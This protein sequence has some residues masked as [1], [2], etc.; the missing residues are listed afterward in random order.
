MGIFKKR[1]RWSTPVRYVW[2]CSAIQDSLRNCEASLVLSVLR[3]TPWSLQEFHWSTMW[4]L[5][6]SK[7]L[8][9]LI[10]RPFKQRDWRISCEFDPLERKRQT[11]FLKINVFEHKTEKSHE[12]NLLCLMAISISVPTTFSGKIIV[13]L[14]FLFNQSLDIKS[15]KI[16]SYWLWNTA[17]GKSI[18][19]TH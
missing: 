2:C 5:W 1:N 7:A 9:N 15:P 8:Y 6:R 17:Y 10:L 16:F 18:S 13:D 11:M 3:D 4:A 19:K 14:A 12:S